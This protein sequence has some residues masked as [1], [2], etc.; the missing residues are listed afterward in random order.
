MSN[1][2]CAQK[3]GMITGRVTDEKNE[4]VELVNVSIFGDPGGTSTTADGSYSLQV[5]AS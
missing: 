2:V 1:I 5:P 4:P 3:M